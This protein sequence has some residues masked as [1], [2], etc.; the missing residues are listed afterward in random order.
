M[1]PKPV[2]LDPT[3]LSTDAFNLN[4]RLK[5]LTIDQDHVVDSFTR[6]LETFFAGF[7]D[8][9]RPVGVVFEL[10]PTGTGKTTVVENQVLPSC[11]P[12]KPSRTRRQPSTR[13]LPARPDPMIRCSLRC[14]IHLRKGSRIGS[15]AVPIWSK[16]APLEFWLGQ[17]HLKWRET[18]FSRLVLSFYAVRIRFGAKHT[19]FRCAFQARSGAQRSVSALF[20]CA[21][22]ARQ[23]RNGLFPRSALRKSTLFRIMPFYSP[24]PSPI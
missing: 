10:G 3:L 13:L 20:H 15:L 23:V 18:V 19:R 2:V 9:E 1:Q 24:A 7:N 11:L 4:R 5:E 21:P 22:R 17:T 8:P 12:T 6:I 16:I 14:S